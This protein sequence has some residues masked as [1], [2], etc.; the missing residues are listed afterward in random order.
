MDHEKVPYSNMIPCD[1]ELD[2]SIYTRK[3]YIILFFYYKQA[4][5]LSSKK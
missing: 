5:I 1:L 4:F 3:S 2:S